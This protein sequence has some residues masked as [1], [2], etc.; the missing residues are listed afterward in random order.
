MS[1]VVRTDVPVIAD[2]III[3]LPDDDHED[4]LR[5]E[6]AIAELVEINIMSLSIGIALMAGLTRYLVV[7]T[8][9]W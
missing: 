8:I 2:R 6:E 3:G 7:P 9:D 5:L 1:I 4:L